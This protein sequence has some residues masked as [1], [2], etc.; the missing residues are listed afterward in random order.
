MMPERLLFGGLTGLVV[1]FLLMLFILPLLRKLKAG[2]EILCFVTLHEGKKGTPTMGGTAILG[3]LTAAACLTVTGSSRLA[4][5][6]M[7]ITLAY[8]VLG[9]LDDYI[10]VKFHRNLGL[11]STQ[12]AVFQFLIAVVAAFKAYTDPAVGGILYIPF[13]RR[14]ID[15]GFLIVPLVIVAF[16]GFTNGVNLTDGIDGLASSVS[17]AVTAA[18]AVLITIDASAYDMAGRFEIA[19]EMG[20]LAVI[21]ASATGCLVSFLI[22]NAYPAKVFMGDTGSMALGALIACLAVF[23]KN[24]VALVIPCLMFVFSALSVMI[25]VAVFKLKKKRVFLMAPFHHHLQ[26]K[27]WSEPRICIVYTAITLIGILVLF[28]GVV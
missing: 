1:T 14:E 2:Q 16:L 7:A 15:I 8:G 20:N 13:A 28:L 4:G 25:Q 19:E 17:A 9:F 10:K 11:T 5:V 6:T 18:I 26:M 24:T 12:K 22:F 21:A 23:S 27:G 3:G